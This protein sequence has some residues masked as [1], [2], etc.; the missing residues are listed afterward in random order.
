[1]PGVDV[2]G[3]SRLRMH[4]LHVRRDGNEW[5]VGR[6]E[7]GDFIAVPRVA[8]D[9]IELLG[10]GL[11]VD[12]THHRLLADHGRDVDVADLA[13]SLVDLGFVAAVDEEAL[14]QDV[15][16][17]TLPGMRRAHVRWLVT[18][19]VGAALAVLA[20]AAAVAAA[21]S[22]HA[23]PAYSDLLWSDRAGMVMAGNAVLAWTIIYLHELAH[24]A[25]ARAYDVPGRL[26]L[27]TR[28]QFLAAQTDVTG[29]WAA[30]RRARLIV[31]LSGLGLNVA[32]A[33]IALIARAVINPD[34]TVGRLCGA[35]VV[36]SVVMVSYQLLVFMR[37]DLYFVLQDV[38]GCRN[39]YGDGS[40]YARWLV[41]RMAR[42]VRP[43][44]GPGPANP[45]AVLPA[46]ERRAVIGYAA[47]LVGGT[48]TCLGVAAIV[49]V[50]FTVGLI[51]VALDTVIH[52]TGAVHVMDALLALATLS[53]FWTLW[54]RAWWR[55][56]GNRVRGWRR[57]SPGPSGPDCD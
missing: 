51:H 56:H 38:A 32:V 53:M 6:K 7:A 22:P 3:G 14:V 8:V 57:R 40:A 46:R 39:L 45:T 16:P 44:P 18:W 31:Y 26:R 48:A 23:V 50:P 36:L 33:S 52:P 19:P 10:A 47:L 34:Q 37:T 12:E 27:G 13:G 55:R 35:V 15:A 41:A 30:P 11:S 21:V 24:L 1:M 25:T 42:F 49:T 4:A 5:I 2:Q 28:L 54:A 43:R 29:I 20:A 17:V 9:A